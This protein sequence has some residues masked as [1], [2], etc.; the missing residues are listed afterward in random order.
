MNEADFWDELEM[1][2]CREFTGAER[3]LHGW[4]CDGFAADDYRLSERPPRI[5]G[6][7]WIGPN[8]AA[9][10]WTFELIL[11]QVATRRDA[12]DWA[13][14][15]PG[16]RMTGWLTVE[17][18]RCHAVIDPGAAKLDLPVPPGSRVLFELRIEDV[19]RVSAGHD[20]LVGPS[21]GSFTMREANLVCELW[22][23]DEFVEDVE[24]VGAVL[25]G[26]S[27]PPEHPPI[28]VRPLDTDL[29]RIRGGNYRLVVRDE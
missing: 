26:G 20:V 27:R 15:L 29:E 10:Q 13:A 17:S 6:S 3:H 2:L 4:W 24:L 19:F 8:A 11:D 7:A 28:S 1:R 25:V 16:E 9:T 23:E 5:L 12:I 22:C 14:L 18:S 21:E